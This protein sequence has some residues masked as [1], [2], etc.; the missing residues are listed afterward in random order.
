MIEYARALVW[1]RR[2]LRD[3]DHAA[4]YHALKRSR[5]V[6]C[7]FIFD[8]DILDALPDPADR[9]VEFIHASVTELQQALQAR[10]GGLVVRHGVARDEVVQ[11][12]ADLQAE[13][14]FFNHDDDPAALARDAAVEAALRARD[15]AVHHSKDAVIFEREDV[16]TAGG[17]PYSVFTPYKNAW[18][19][20]LTPFDLQA[21]PVEAYAGRL[22]PQ[23][24]AIP[25][26]PDMGF[27]PTNLA[28]LR[29]PTGMSGG[30]QL[31]EDF[32]QRIDRYQ[33]LRDYPAVKGPSYLSVHLRFGTVSIR[34][35]AAAAWQRGGRGAQTWLSELIWRDFYHQI[36]WHRPDVASGH[37]FKRQYDA[38]PWPNPPGHFEAW[39]EARTGYP[40][41]DAAM[42]Q[43]NQTGY[44]HNRLRMV[45]ASFLTKDLLVDW[46]LGEKYFADKLIDFDLAANSGGWQWAA[47]VGCDAQPWFRI[48]NPVTQS[49]RFDAEGHFIRR[50]L[51]ELARVAEKFIHAPWAMPAAEQQRAGCVIGRD[52]PLPIV[53]HAVQRGQTLA[54]FRQALPPAL[55]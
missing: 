16:L 7:A 37:S 1:F 22:A 17:T 50:Y 43:L 12:A 23:S 18:L 42:R 24:S 8:R 28:E 13:A 14:V 41:I 29:L 44:M 27:E 39:C 20:R 9:R 26:L 10:G 31:F 4:L 52:C 33:A 21:Y 38:L 25:R 55:K 49:E 46:R 53:D 32:L 51:P 15:I 40:L 45:T 11:L 30:A 47:S 54:L 5:Q 35:L 48:F 6:V 19:K 2:D 34:Q 3:F 36:L